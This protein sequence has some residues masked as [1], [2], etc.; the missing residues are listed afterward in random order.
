M[1]PR[2]GYACSMAATTDRP[3][4]APHEDPRGNGAVL[5][6]DGLGRPVQVPHDSLRARIRRK[7]GI[8]QA[9]RV[10]VFVVGLLFI[11]LGIA[12]MALPGPLTIPP[13]LLGLWIWSTEFAF[14]DRFFQ[15]FK[16]KAEE[17][18]DHAKQHPR[19]SALVTGGG[20]VAAAVAFWAVQRFELVD[21]AKAALF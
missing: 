13:V 9:W 10:G 15:S 7:P 14:A 20:L 16:R 11:G 5:L 3:R 1:T 6:E 2:S 8:A 4:R 19:T 18:W 17:A 21:Q 12:L